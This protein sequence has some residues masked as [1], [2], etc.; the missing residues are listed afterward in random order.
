MEGPESRP[1]NLMAPE[2][3]NCANRRNRRS[4]LTLSL[5][6]IFFKCP[7]WGCLDCGSNLKARDCPSWFHAG[8]PGL[9]ITTFWNLEPSKGQE[10]RASEEWG[11]GAL[12]TMRSPRPRGSQSLLSRRVSDKDF[13][14]AHFSPRQRLPMGLPSLLF[15]LCILGN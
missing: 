2:V 9:G 4:W 6:C 11:L 3:P 7:N 8:F 12:H 10:P 1:V 14:S 5:K 15:T 13:Q